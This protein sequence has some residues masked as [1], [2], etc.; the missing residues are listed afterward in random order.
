M[1]PNWHKSCEL[2]SQVSKFGYND[3]LSFFKFFDGG[4]GFGRPG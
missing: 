2:D 3:N 1:Y 4:T